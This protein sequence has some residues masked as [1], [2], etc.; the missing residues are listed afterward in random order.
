MNK[1]CNKHFTKATKGILFVD[2]MPLFD[3]LV[4]FFVNL[5]SIFF[6]QMM[7]ARLHS[8]KHP[9]KKRKATQEQASNTN[10]RKNS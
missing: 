1:V 10:E 6:L 2:F 4:I 7:L 3:N 8:M 9:D 5:P